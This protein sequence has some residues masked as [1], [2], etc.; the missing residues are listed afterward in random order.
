MKRTNG[1]RPTQRAIADALGVVPSRVVALRVAG[2]PCNSIDDAVRWHRANIRPEPNRRRAGLPPP[3][4][5]A[6]RSYAA[7]R[8]SREHFEA[9]L[10]QLRYQQEIGKLVDASRVRAELGKHLVALRDSLLGLPSRLASQLAAESTPQRCQELVA[11]EI[12]AILT[13]LT[14]I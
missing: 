9:K 6:H 11:A 3:P 14:E 12:D 4:D 2:M 1:S 5:E 10:A 13:R 7:S 8:A